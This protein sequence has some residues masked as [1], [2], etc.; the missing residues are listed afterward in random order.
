MGKMW[1]EQA[2]TGRDPKLLSRLSF[3]SHYHCLC[4]AWCNQAAA[5]TQQLPCCKI[6]FGME[7][8]GAR[9]RPSWSLGC[10]IA[11]LKSC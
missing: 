11:A 3:E 7:E 8:E 1:G 9:V 10:Q 5:G 4:L 2:T 6:L